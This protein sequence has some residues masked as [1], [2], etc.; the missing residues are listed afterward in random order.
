MEGCGTIIPARISLSIRPESSQLEC[1]FSLNGERFPREPASLPSQQLLE[2][3]RSDIK[4]AAAGFPVPS[5]STQSMRRELRKI[6]PRTVI[7]AVRNA[8]AAVPEASTLALEIKLNDPEIL[9]PYPW[10]LLSEQGILASRKKAVTV[11]RSVPAPKFSRRPSSSVLLVGSASFDTTSTDAAGEIAVLAELLRNSTGIYPYEKPHITFA[12]FLELLRALD[13]SVIHV[14]THGNMDGFQFQKDPEASRTHDNIPPQ[15][16][17][18]YLAQS[19]TASLVLLNAC[20]SASSWDDHTSVARSSM[21]RRIATTSSATTIGMSAEIPNVVGFDFSKSFF[22]ALVSGDSLIE[23]FGAAT[24][25]IRREK[26]FANL[27]STLVMYAPPDSNVVLFPADPMG[28]TR[29]RFQELGRQLRQLDFETAALT[30]HDLSQALNSI[31]SIGTVKVRLAYIRDLL[32]EVETSALEGP[33][34]L[35]AR[36]LLAQVQNHIG[37]A[38]GQL[39][40]VLGNLQDPRRSR[41]QRDQATQSIRRVLAEQIR[42]FAQLEREF[43]DSR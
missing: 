35:R 6:I 7:A 2:A 19:P 9:D 13:P 16:I 22:E 38:L 32:D 27:W 28:R 42:T 34:R 23:A 43:S 40:I 12:E 36:R 41:D 15:E 26:N 21:A 20:G 3:Y 31:P 30:S 11:W 8:V 25:A 29:L 39:Q 33:E 10:E 5:S 37:R 14:I 4:L 18:A 1:A 24:R 17:G